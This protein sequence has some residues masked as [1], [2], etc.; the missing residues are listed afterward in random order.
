MSD[1]DE[2]VSLADVVYAWQEVAVKGVLLPEGT[3][4][5]DAHFVVIA[6]SDPGS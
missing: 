2:E 3:L 6:D 4:S 5:V 1:D